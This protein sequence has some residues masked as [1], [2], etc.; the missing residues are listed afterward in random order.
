MTQLLNSLASSVRHAILGAVRDARG[1][2]AVEF[3][4]LSP[5]L[6]LMLLGCVEFG[7]AVAIERRIDLVTSRVG[8]MVAR[9]ETMSA[10][11]INAI[12]DIAEHIMA[13][14]DA[15]SLQLSVIPVAPSQSDETIVKVYA[16]TTNR[17]SM[18]GGSQPEQC[19]VY[20]LA[21]LLGANDKAIVVEASY[22]YTPLF[23]GFL[24]PSATWT[25]KSVHSPREGCVDFDGN[26]CSR[27]S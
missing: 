20:T 25:N 18:H 23:V 8:D 27:C 5:I 15:S 24:I 10:D 22:S 21:E 4:L 14:Y 11:N 13:P 7:R 9:E 26:S 3:G 6:L 16:G 2:A 1:V 12:Y 17:P 19:S